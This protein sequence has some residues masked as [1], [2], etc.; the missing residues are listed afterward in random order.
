MAPAKP[1]SVRASLAK[2]R[3]RS[4]MKYPTRRKGWRSGSLRGGHFEYLGSDY[5]FHVSPLSEEARRHIDS[6]GQ[7]GDEEADRQGLRDRGQKMPTT[8]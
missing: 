6:E 5:L 7:S 2:A 1:M 4:T 8:T 3:A